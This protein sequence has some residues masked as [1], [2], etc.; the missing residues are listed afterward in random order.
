MSTLLEKARKFTRKRTRKEYKVTSEHIELA[1]AYLNHEITMKQFSQ[2]LGGKNR[3]GS[4]N[5]YLIAII[6]EM[7]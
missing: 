6:R 3:S 2:A 1:K 7:L 5:A 4:E